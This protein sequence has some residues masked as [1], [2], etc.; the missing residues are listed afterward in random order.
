MTYSFVLDADQEVPAPALGEATPSGEATVEVDSVTGAFAVTGIYSGLTSAATAAHIHG[1]ADPGVAAGVLVGLTVSG[2][3]DGTIGGAGSLGPDD[4]EL[5][6]A[7]RTYINVHTVNNG[8]GEIRGQI[9]DPD[10]RRFGI[11]LTT[12]AEIPAPTLDGAFPSGSAQVVVDGESGVVEV[13]GSYSGMTSEVE[14]AHLHGLADREATAGVLFGLTTGGGTSGTIAGGGTLA[15]DDL[16]GLFAGL[17]YLN[18][19]TADNPPG[20][21]RGQVTDNRIRQFEFGLSAE[22]EVPVPDTTGG[23]P[24]GRAEVAVDTVSGRTRINGTYDG[25]TSAVNAAHLHGFAEPGVAV[26]VLFGLATSGGTS[27]T[28]S[29]AST[30][31]ADAVEN[32][33]AGLTYINVHTANNPPGEIRGQVVTELADLPPIQLIPVVEDAIASPVALAHAGDGSGRLFVADQRGTIHVIRAGTLLP[34]PFLD[35]SDELVPE[36]ANFDERGLLGLAF[37]PG[38]ADAGHPGEGKFYIYYSAPSPDATPPGDPDPID[39]MS[40]VS[41]F[42]VS[43][44]DPDVAD[45]ASERVL[46][47]INQPQFNHDGGQLDFGPED[48]LLYISTGD[49]GSSDD[50][51]AGHTGGSAD[52]PA[53]ALGNAQDLSNL[54]GKILRI[55]PLGTDGPEA[56]YGIPGDNPFVGLAAPVRG[57]IFAFGLRNPWRCS[58][59]R[60]EGGT[61]RLFV[62]DVG[63]GAVEEINIVEPG[64][65]YGWRVEEGTFDFAPETP[66]TGPFE[67]PV[68]EYAHPDTPVGLPEIGISVTGGYVY[69]GS[70][71]SALQGIYIFGDWSNNFGAPNGTLLGLRETDP[72]KFQLGIFPVLA[73]NPVGRFVPAFG[74]DEDGEV[75]VATKS[76]LAPSAPDPVTGLPTGSIYRVAAATLRVFTGL[77]LTTGQEV[78]TPVLG[79]ATPTGVATVEVD[80]A[81]GNVSIEGS[82]TGMTSPVTAAHL[83]GLAGPG[84]TAPPI[85]TLDVDGETSGGF[86]GTGML[87]AA[88]LEG[89]LL[90]QTYLNVHTAANGPGEIRGQV[91]GTVASG[92]AITR[93]G[94]DVEIDWD[95]PTGTLDLEESGDAATWVPSVHVPDEFSGRKSVTVSDPTGTR[96]FRLR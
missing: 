52:R 12:G 95:D 79:G 77:R 67:R 91:P 10:I 40:V 55:D 24:E 63:Q 62:A 75:Y 21:I 81:T 46:L 30:L 61:N 43:A 36:R 19:H 4:L 11:L 27:G 57:E 65:N 96:L 47:T 71:S 49:G 86:R 44:G 69:R 60:V 29:G 51:N 39:H 90:G 74:S 28:F 87:G 32:L 16:A 94:A 13:S 54:L 70:A 18:V 33:L 80:T 72:G 66:V 58:F 5:L 41:E 7:G 48:E 31:E 92:L 56:E 82:Y 84:D 17:T 83:H 64:G 3:T 6:L 59:D 35:V 23:T 25:M 50:N 78:P 22:Q 76:T 53:D 14:A 15:A 85:I 38:Y 37:H 9:T 73:G 88:D 2:S 8:P 34:T 68:A 89:L 20:E 93:N 26:G 42:S 45:P 1:P